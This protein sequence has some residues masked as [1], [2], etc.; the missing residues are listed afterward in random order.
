M[1]KINNNINRGFEAMLP[2]SQ[3]VKKN[4]VFKNEIQFSLFGREFY[5]G[6]HV[7]KPQE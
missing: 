1:T 5:L 7:N 6:F 2:K 4:Y 3:E